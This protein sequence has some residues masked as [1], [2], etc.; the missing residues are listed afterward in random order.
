MT[1]SDRNFLILFSILAFV[2]LFIASE[3]IVIWYLIKYRKTDTKLLT[4]DSFER[5]CDLSRRCDSDICVHYYKIYTLGKGLTIDYPV[6]FHMN[7]DSLIHGIVKHDT[8]YQS[9]KSSGYFWYKVVNLYGSRATLTT[10]RRDHKIND[11]V[12]S[13]GGDCHVAI[14]KS[15]PHQLK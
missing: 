2:F 8:V 4:I 13:Q 14:I 10:V 6:N 12:Y 5:R 3:S 7:W 1:R 9:P 15:K 11:T